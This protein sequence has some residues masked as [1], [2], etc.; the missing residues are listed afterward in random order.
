MTT[1][2][3]IKNA[4]LRTISTTEDAR[5]SRIKVN[6]SMPWR[7]NVVHGHTKVLCST[8]VYS[9]NKMEQQISVANK[10]HL[11]AKNLNLKLSRTLA[12]STKAQSPLVIVIVLNG[13]R[14]KLSHMF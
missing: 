2:H 8:K 3:S 4:W 11:E 13:Q 7:P 9:K 14:V 5:N 10:F 6:Q 12:V 1:T